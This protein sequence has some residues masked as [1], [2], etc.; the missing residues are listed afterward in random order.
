MPEQ[1]LPGQNMA[2]CKRMDEVEIHGEY[3]HWV[4]DAKPPCK[5]EGKED[6]SLWKGACYVPSYPAGRKPTVS[7]LLLSW[8]R[9]PRRTALLGTGT[10]PP[11]HA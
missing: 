6:A 11:L 7:A 5:E 1:S 9:G 8:F 4:P 2:P 10:G 3:W